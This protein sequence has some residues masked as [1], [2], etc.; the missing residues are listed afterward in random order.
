MA[1]GILILRVGASGTYSS[2]MI[3]RGC[4]HAIGYCS[5]RYSRMSYQQTQFFL[6]DLEERRSQL[7]WNEFALRYA[8]HPMSLSAGVDSQNGGG[9]SCL[10]AFSFKIS[11]IRST[12]SS[13][14]A[15][16]RT[17]R[18]SKPWILHVRRFG[19]RDASSGAAPPGQGTRF[20]P[21]ESCLGET[22]CR[23]TIFD[24]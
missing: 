13:R 8:G 16:C 1:P 23:P 10:L 2:E 5:H 3:R 7:V 18:I 15:S 6:H 24:A 4:L 12:R 14:I 19:E 17:P 11:P 9:W 21:W 22:A 20:V